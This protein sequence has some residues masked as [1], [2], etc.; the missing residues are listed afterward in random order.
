[1]ARDWGVQIRT[2]EARIS[3]ELPRRFQAMAQ[4]RADALYV[5]GDNFTLTQMTYGPSVPEMLRRL[6]TF[7]DRI[8]KGG[9]PDDLPIEQPTTFE[10]V[11]N[12]KTAKAL[13]L[14]VPP[15][16]LLRANQVID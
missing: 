2:F 4:E 14:A 10:L 13:G 7:I 6:S 16:L 3:T 5:V 11:I 8:L 9:N 15:A 12:M 1:V